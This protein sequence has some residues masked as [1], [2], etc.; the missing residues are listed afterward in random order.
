M[1]LGNRIPGR[2]QDSFEV[3]GHELKV[4]A[5]SLVVCPLL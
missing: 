3:K 5:V 4:G 1:G 2:I